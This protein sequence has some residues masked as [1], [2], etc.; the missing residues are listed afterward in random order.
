MPS[1]LKLLAIGITSVAAGGGICYAAEDLMLV[2]QEYLNWFKGPQW[3]FGSTTAAEMAWSDLLYAGVL[4]SVTGFLAWFGISDR[5]RRGSAR[6]EFTE[7]GADVDNPFAAPSS[8]QARPRSASSPGTGAFAA[9]WPWIAVGVSG[10]TLS[11]LFWLETQPP[12]IRL[13]PHMSTVFLVGVPAQ[14]VVTIPTVAEFV[15]TVPVR[16]LR[17]RLALGVVAL[18]FHAV[19]V[20]A[21]FVAIRRYLRRY[22][23]SGGDAQKGAGNPVPS[24]S[25]SIS[26][27]RRVDREDT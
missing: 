24:E 22:Q 19:F 4:L 20:I 15:R 17:L 2:S 14:L 6:T 5:L 11:F 3:S 1:V 12:A 10:I 26:D 27:S 23:A 21:Y 9:V 8:T 13:L 16:S 18:M 25:P 7:A